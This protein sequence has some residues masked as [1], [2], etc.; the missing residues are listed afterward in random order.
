MADHRRN[1]QRRRCR[2][3]GGGRTACKRFFRNDP[4][5]SCSA[6]ARPAAPGCASKCLAGQNQVVQRACRTMF[7]HGE[8]G[9]CATVIKR[10]IADEFAQLDNTT[11]PAG[12]I[13]AQPGPDT[14]FTIG[15][16]D[17]PLARQ[18]VADQVDALRALKRCPPV[19]RAFCTSVSS[20]SAK[21]PRSRESVDRCAAGA[22]SP[23]P[24][25]RCSGFRA[26]CASWTRDRRRGFSVG[27]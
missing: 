16:A 27:R 3:P 26:S 9:V 21:G 12:G 6:L 22:I 4:G 7:E 25:H 14:L 8:G 13:G 20:S 19:R 11:M 1:G 5:R 10:G 15:R 23:A 18:R 24:Q 17:T 2:A